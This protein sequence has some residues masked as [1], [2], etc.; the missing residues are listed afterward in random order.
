MHASFG[1]NGISCPIETPIL[2]T[3]ENYTFT[4]VLRAYSELEIFQTGRS[5]NVGGW[6][7]LV[8]DIRIEPFTSRSICTSHEFFTNYVAK[9]Q[10]EE[11]PDF[12]NRDPKKNTTKEVFDDMKIQK[13]LSKEFNVYLSK[14]KFEMVEK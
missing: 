12:S 2:L 10:Q 5:S 3:V 14:K 11:D 1:K 9:R 7:P 6:K 13:E 8:F 4:P